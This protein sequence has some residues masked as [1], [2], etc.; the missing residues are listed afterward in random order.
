MDRF[1]RPSLKT[2]AVQQYEEPSNLKEIQRFLGLAGYFRNFIENFATIAKP[3]S[4]LLRQNQQFKFE[5][6]E[7]IAFERLKTIISERPVLTIFQYGLET[8]VHTDASR[9]ALAAILMQR[10]NEDDKMHP[11][12]Y[13]SI[14]TSLAEDK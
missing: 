5:L 12:R 6:A 14:K 4:D 10:S 13:M 1:A 8:E 7:R 11:V 2:K 3:L 9:Y